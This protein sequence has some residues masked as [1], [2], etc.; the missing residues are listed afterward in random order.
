MKPFRKFPKV[1]NALCFS[2]P[3]TFQSQ[4][5][6]KLQR[7]HSFLGEATRPLTDC[8]TR[9][10]IIRCDGS[11]QK[12]FS[13]SFW[14][15]KTSSILARV[16]E[17]QRTTFKSRESH[18]FPNPI[19]GKCHA[20]RWL[21]DRRGQREVSEPPLVRRDNKSHRS[22]RSAV[23]RELG[24]VNQRGGRGRGGAR[25]TESR[26]PPPFCFQIPPS[27]RVC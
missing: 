23:F 26:V 17:I 25:P 6:I 1:C 9:R 18:L 22:E 15:Q 2:R 13:H 14:E 11:Q 7:H 8:S 19:F 21:F 4:L 5:S 10:V 24:A 12:Q 16:R 3:Q 27:P 20:A